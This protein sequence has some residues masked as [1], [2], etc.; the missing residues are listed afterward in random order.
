MM[1]RERNCEICLSK[2]GIGRH[3]R[4][5]T[6]VSR[7][8]AEQM[9]SEKQTFPVPRSQSP[10]SFAPLILL[11]AI[12]LVI[13]IVTTGLVL[14]P[15]LLPNLG[16]SGG[17]SH[18]SYV[19]IAIGVP[20]FIASFVGEAMNKSGQEQAGALVALL[21][22][23]IGLVLQVLVGMP[24]FAG[25]IYAA[26]AAPAD[27]SSPSASDRAM[28]ADA[29]RPRAPSELSS[30]ESS[31]RAATTCAPSARPH[32]SW[33]AR[34]AATDAGE[35]STNTTDSAPRLRASIPS[36]PVP[37]K[38]STNVASATSPSEPSEL[39]SASRTLDEVGRTS[40][41]AGARRAA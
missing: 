10:C 33:L 7:I 21:G 39:N 11:V 34:T 22:A 29:P 5:L 1:R 24:L 25:A 19:T 36:A 12:E 20:Q 3:S 28:P 26:A 18:H 41:P 40:R 23:C 13:Y 6:L 17:H 37:A 14:L 31:R 4:F 32:A 2:S 38:R 15:V 27:A 35:R 30:N 9:K 8:S 16:I